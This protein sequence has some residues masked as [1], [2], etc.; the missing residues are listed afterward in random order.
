VLYRYDVLDQA[1]EVEVQ[2]HI[3]LRFSRNALG[4]ITDEVLSA[5]L[6]RRI[7]YNSDGYLTAQ[8]MFAAERPVCEQR[9]IYDRAGNS[10]KSAILPWASTGILTI[11]SGAWSTT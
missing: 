1:S 6:Q 11:P 8:Q 9:Y 7:A 3:P 4:Q 10:S 5:S 2:G